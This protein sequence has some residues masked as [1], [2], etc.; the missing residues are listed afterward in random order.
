M[1]R[2][3]NIQYEG[4]VGK[5]ALAQPS[6]AGSITQSGTGEVDAS[7]AQNM[8]QRVTYDVRRTT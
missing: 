1:K 4:Q 8:C 2:R 3:Y 5:A 7:A 6:D